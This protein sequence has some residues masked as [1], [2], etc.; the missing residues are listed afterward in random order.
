MGIPSL[1]RTLVH[2]DPNLFHNRPPRECAFFYLDYN[3]L[4]HH[5]S[6]LGSFTTDED[7]I[8]QVVAYTRV[9]INDIVK[10][11]ELLYIAMDGPV[12]VAKMIRQR[13][14]RFKKTTNESVF[15][16]SK[17]TPGTEFMSK[18]SQRIK[19]LISLNV[20]SCV[21]HIVFSDSSIPGEG[22]WK[23][24][25]N[26]RSVPK[27]AH[28]CV[29]GLDAD[30]IVWSM[31]NDRIHK[32]LV[33][34]RENEENQMMFFELYDA[35]HILLKAHKLDTSTLLDIV[36]ILML[37]GNDFVSPIE[38]L[39]IRYN[40]W[41][42]LLTCYA[43]FGKRF[44]TDSVDWNLFYSFLEYVSM[45]EDS[46]SKKMYT[47]QLRASNKKSNADIEHTP[48]AS[49]DHPW[50]PLYGKQ[51]I[52]IPY[53]DQHTVWKPQYYERIFGHS[54]KIPGFM[55]GI[56]RDYVASI[57]W[58]WE[59]YTSPNVPSWT[60][61][62]EYIAAPCLTDLVFWYHRV[63]QDAVKCAFYDYMGTCLTPVEQLA[64]VLPLLKSSDI[65][66]TVVR[67]SLSVPENPLMDFQVSDPLIEPITSQK[68]I[69]APPLLPPLDIPKIRHVVA[70]LSEYFTHEEHER[71]TVYTNP[72]EFKRI[73]H[74]NE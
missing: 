69:Y 43:A 56:C 4:I 61:C 15:D 1:F 14:R 64:C 19:S 13:E 29:Y 45:Y 38:C 8:T 51:S 40:G 50:Y 44:V 2:D 18:L 42:T 66:P 62:F 12:P 35:L 74:M 41:D 25:Q 24:F 58:C 71:N 34:C 37:G 46:L 30:L 49:T 48:F 28:V 31:A 6:R 16:S 63:F 36:L 67:D 53:F 33:L 47:R 23:I 59:Y 3:C 11:S 7:V 60:F 55:P 73:K 32:N 10:P 57:I 72:F 70:C 17:I 54:F 27:H 20:F 68:W 26:L 9:L 39:K 22:E 21:K 52:G 65:V 5:A